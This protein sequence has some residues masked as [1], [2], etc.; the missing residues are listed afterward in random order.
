MKRSSI[1]KLILLVWAL[2]SAASGQ[3]PATPATSGETP[4]DA[5][6]LNAAVFDF[7]EGSDKVKGLGESVGKLLNAELS[8][9][10]GMFLV[11]R[12][13]LEK[14]LSEQ[15]ITLS[16]AAA[17]GS[18]V[19]VGQLTGAQVLVTGRVF[20]VGKD[21]YLVAK[22]ISA[23]TSRVYGATSKYRA[24]GDPGVAANELAGKIA[25]L[26]TTKGETLVAKAMSFEDRVAGLKQA[27]ADVKELPAI[28]VQ[29]SETHLRQQVPDPACETELQKLLQ[30][31]GFPVV[32]NRSEAKYSITGEAFSQFATRRG[33]LVCCRARAEIKIEEVAT[34]KLVRPDRRT[35]GAIDLA[36][37][38]AG[39]A[40]LQKAGLEL[41]DAFIRNLPR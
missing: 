13:E 11:E 14:I 5:I 33:N 19:K 38:V 28:Y 36:E 24:D 25:N 40:A 15:E 20:D 30:A 32:K 29:V 22:L 21:T 41:A 37:E 31:V 18:A 34:N 26:I 1:S 23:E 4:K 35:V 39:K 3:Q 12:A 27:V 2:A 9:Q 6:P 8:T 7:T 17:P 10:P 16:G